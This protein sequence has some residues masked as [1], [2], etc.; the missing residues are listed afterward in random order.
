MY[1]QLPSASLW[2]LLGSDP[3]NHRSGYLAT[4]SQRR[5][6]YLRQKRYISL[7]QSRKVTLTLLGMLH[8]HN[9]DLA[10]W[11][12]SQASRA[13]QRRKSPCRASHSWKGCWSEC[14]AFQKVLGYHKECRSRTPKSTLSMTYCWDSYRKKL[15]RLPKT[16]RRDP[17]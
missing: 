16:I 10:I 7:P 13:S 17:L 9:T 14:E 3:S 5:Y 6:Y 8:H 1:V 2:R 4:N 15:G 12:T 11:M